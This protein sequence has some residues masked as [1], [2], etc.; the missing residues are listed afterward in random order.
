MEVFTKLNAVEDEVFQEMDRS[1]KQIN[2][3]HQKFT[4]PYG[5]T[6]IFRTSEAIFPSCLVSTF[7]IV[8]K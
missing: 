4:S 6:R 5:G 7:Y 8:F 3:F 1:E 2:D